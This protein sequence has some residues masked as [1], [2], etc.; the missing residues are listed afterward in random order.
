MKNTLKTRIQ[1]L[2]R[3]ESRD[4]ATTTIQHSCLPRQDL[5][6]LFSPVPY[7]IQFRYSSSLRPPAS[8]G[9]GLG[10]HAFSP[11][12]APGLQQ[13][14]E[15]APAFG[16]LIQP[17]RDWLVP[18]F[19][20]LFSAHESCATNSI[21]LKHNNACNAWITGESTV[22]LKHCKTFSLEEFSKTL[23]GL[24][25]TSD[26]PRS[27]VAPHASAHRSAE[28]YA[29]GPARDTGC[30]GTGSA[31][32]GVESLSSRDPRRTQRPAWCRSYR[33]AGLRSDGKR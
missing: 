16:G 24:L 9:C 8:P 30:R 18:S 11:K 31:I 28:K 15:F 1:D 32:R 3:G 19:W 7:P 10:L 23:G 12:A 26:R 2:S 17:S 33:P 13:T 27:S 5:P 22:N 25:R 6:D 20:R 21:K 14:S 4:F 29:T